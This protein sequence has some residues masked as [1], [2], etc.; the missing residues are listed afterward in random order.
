MECPVGADGTPCGEGTGVG[1]CEYTDEQKDILASGRLDDNGHLIAYEEPKMSLFGQCKCVSKE[2]S[3]NKNCDME[4]QQCNEHS[5]NTTLYSKAG[6]WTLGDE[7][8]F[9]GS[10]SGTGNVRNNLDT[11]TL[12]LRK[13]ENIQSITLQSSWLQR[14]E[15]RK[16]TSTHL[17]YNNILSLDH[18]LVTCGDSEFANYFDRG[19]RCANGTISVDKTD[20]SDYVIY[21]QHHVQ[22]YKVMVATEALYPHFDE[23]KCDRNKACSY[24]PPYY[25]ASECHISNKIT[26]RAECELIGDFVTWNS[27]QGCIVREIVEK[28]SGFYDNSITKEECLA[29]T[30]FN[31][32][33]DTNNKPK[34]C[35][36]ETSESSDSNIYYNNNKDVFD[37]ACNT[38]TPCL[39][40]KIYN[41]VCK[42]TVALNA[43]GRYVKLE[44][45]TCTANKD[46]NSYNR[47]GDPSDDWKKM[48]PCESDCDSTDDCL[49]GSCYS[50]DHS[51]DIP[52]GCPGASS[53][54]G[55]HDFCY[56]PHVPIQCHIRFGVDIVQGGKIG[57]C[58]GS[59][60]FCDCQ[61]PFTNFKEEISFNWKG[62]EQKQLVKNYGVPSLGY[63]FIRYGECEGGVE[64]RMS[65]YSCNEDKAQ[66]IED[67]FQLCKNLELRSE[68]GYKGFLVFFSTTGGQCWCETASAYTCSVRANTEHY[69]RFEFTGYKPSTTELS[70]IRMKQGRE[71]FIKNYLKMAF[72][73]SKAYKVSR[74]KRRK[75]YNDLKYEIRE[76]GD[77]LC[78]HPIESLEECKQALKDLGFINWDSAVTST[79][80]ILP[81][82]CLFDSWG[83]AYFL[84]GVYDGSAYIDR[85]YICKGVEQ[86]WVEVYNE[87][88]DNPEQF[89]CPRT[90][91]MLNRDQ[92]LEASNTMGLNGGS[93]DF[94][95]AETIVPYG[96]SFYV[97]P[98]AQ[99]YSRVAWN[100]N[101]NGF[102]NI[103]D[104][105]TKV[106][107]DPAHW[108]AYSF[109]RRVCLVGDRYVLADGETDEC[110][111]RQ[112]VANDFNKLSELEDTSAFY[113]FDCNGVCPGTN[114][115]TLIPCNNHGR[116]TVSGQCACEKA[117]IT[118]YSTEKAIST[119]V[120][121]QARSNIVESKFDTTGWRGE[122]CEIKCPGYDENTKSMLN[123][124][125]GHGVC[126]N[127]G[128]C[129]CQMGYIGEE[130][131]FKCPGF[132]D[133]EDTVCSGHGRCELSVIDIT[134][135]PNLRSTS[136]CSTYSDWG[137]CK[138]GFRS[139]T[140]LLDNTTV[141]NNCV[142][143][144]FEKCSHSYNCIGEWGEWNVTQFVISREFIVKDPGSKNDCPKSP[145][146]FNG[147]FIEFQEL[148]R[149][150]PT[151]SF[152]LKSTVP[153]TKAIDL[154]F[155]VENDQYIFNQQQ[156][157]VIRL[158]QN[159]LYTFKRMDAGHPLRVV[160]A[161]TCNSCGLTNY[162]DLPSTSIFQYDVTNTQPQSAIFTNIGEYWYLC[163]THD[164]MIGRI[165]IEKCD[166][167][168]LDFS[169]NSTLKS[170]VT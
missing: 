27:T 107:T 127:D 135:T 60:G 136:P 82:G 36:K 64:T 161:D 15:K 9:I 85:T 156:E 25:L 133:G 105:L 152:K 50:R 16:I 23:Y 138:D 37:K 111:F 80:T 79:H 7:N 76:P 148:Q 109:N 102:H 18:C 34:G 49:S 90:P 95:M 3:K 41:E 20:T 33:T 134:N 120:G 48:G 42:D 144:I 126:N 160:A 121:G 99:D 28:T 12:D 131:E 44:P 151:E 5:Y 75:A 32:E 166:N 86:D 143:Q 125:N 137:P 154:E 116:C 93:G 1:M 158:C 47:G 87:F 101:L 29:L 113:N 89:A 45:L 100:S 13:D 6:V 104:T 164:E 141:E 142:R 168:F 119:E 58:E 162:G 51:T 19:C 98:N 59:N 66:C 4:C 124:C 149:E 81:Y 117:Y 153:N 17:E 78:E 118:K 30:G 94:D 103:K 14:Y 150:T 106:C 56:I 43:Y 21:V 55:T 108:C 112:C 26:S 140:L 97:D 139:K 130:C 70:T 62:Q 170:L 54:V 146:I 123:V 132:D 159:T 24:K 11:I 92:C 63:E 167:A 74:W 68:T 71:S 67:C 65:D 122:A 10:V 73:E 52:D 165:I 83:S 110:D 8:T 35:Y 38:N 57:I 147:S 39:K 91:Q 31:I 53:I 69:S 163:T 77:A 129:E 46:Y 61:P 88:R 84:N 155:S 145:Q 22:T 128:A 169:M 96:C 72:V 115:R 2:G 114:N 40:R 157:P